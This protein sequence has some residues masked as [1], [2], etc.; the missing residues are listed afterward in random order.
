MR[1]DSVKRPIYHRMQISQ[2]LKSIDLLINAELYIFLTGQLQRQKVYT[3]RV[4]GVFRSFANILNG[5]KT[6]C[7][8]SDEGKRAILLSK[9]F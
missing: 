7:L 2:Y 8:F 9:L 4:S 5:R 6:G 3:L 1:R